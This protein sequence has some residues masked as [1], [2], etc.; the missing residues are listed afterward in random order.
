MSAFLDALGFA[1]TG[2]KVISVAKAAVRAAVGISV[3]GARVDA[4]F[5]A[6]GTTVTLAGT[7]FGLGLGGGAGFQPGDQITRAITGYFRVFK[8]LSTMSPL[9][10]Y[11]LTN[12][13]APTV[14]AMKGCD[15]ILTT[16]AANA[17]NFGGSLDYY[18]FY[19]KGEPNRPRWAWFAAGA[20]VSAG[21]S[22]TLMQY[23][24]DTLQIGC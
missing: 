4:K 13:D 1:D 7:G 23:K 14:D 15:L 21:G 6:N 19:K 3:G 24:F 16:F 12:D 18:A 11:W 22:A 5:D 20:E 10:R 2:W 8:F 17:S 9:F